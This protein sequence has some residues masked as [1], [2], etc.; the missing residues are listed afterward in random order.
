LWR[1]L[2]NDCT[3]NASSRTGV[4]VGSAV[5]GA[6]ITLIIVAVIL[7]I[8]LRKMPAKKKLKDVEE[9]KWAKTIKGAK[10]AKVCFHSIIL[11]R[12]SLYFV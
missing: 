3:A 9:N 7:F 11:I 5:G 12:I 1:P 6:V 2:S 8:V 4:I 10:G